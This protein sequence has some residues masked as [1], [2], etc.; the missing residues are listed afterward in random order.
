MITNLQIL[1]AFAALGVVFYHT[2]F[3]IA[4]VS[5]EFFGVPI[6][7]C[8]SGFIMTHIAHE[9]PD[10][11]LVRRLVRIVPIYWIAT[12]LMFFLEQQGLLN[13]PYTGGVWLNFIL[14][15]PRSLATWIA[16]HSGSADAFSQLLKSLFF[17]PY[18]GPSGSMQPVLAVGWTLNLEMYFYALFWVFIQ[19][20]RRYAPLMV[21]TAVVTVMGLSLAS[22]DQYIQFYGR[23][24]TMFF[25]FGIASF[26][27]WRAMPEN[28]LTRYR[29]IVCIAMLTFFVFYVAWQFSLSVQVIAASWLPLNLQNYFAYALPPLFVLMVLVCHR[30]SLS[31]KWNLGILLGNASYSLYLFHVMVLE[32]MRPIGTIYPWFDASKNTLIMILAIAGCSAV[33]VVIYRKIELPLHDLG[34]R[35]LFK[36]RQEEAVAAV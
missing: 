21:A 9:A 29:A 3:T 17:I 22:A 18:V 23:L 19:V 30:A 26:Y 12:L 14:H 36:R 31:P 4:G 33:G 1:R 20:N 10:N 15:E 2:G 5:T 27:A 24:D 32:M 25:I 7:F 28:I 34:K 13:L 35:I 6:F 11:F 8:I 16:S